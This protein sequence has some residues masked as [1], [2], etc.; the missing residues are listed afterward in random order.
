M[1]V[2]F[3][4]S[5]QIDEEFISSIK[6]ISTFV[7]TII[8]CGIGETK[9]K[10][11]Q[12]SSNKLKEEIKVLGSSLSSIKDEYVGRVLNDI[13]S[14]KKDQLKRNNKA[15]KEL[16][17]EL[18]P[19]KKQISEYIDY[20]NHVAHV[21]MSQYSDHTLKAIAD[22]NFSND[23]FYFIAFAL[24]ISSRKTRYNKGWDLYLEGNTRRYEILRE[25]NKGLD[26]F[27]KWVKEN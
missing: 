13:I 15:E 6:I 12:N 19:F 11:V 1:Q 21:F 26:S 9:L 27:I 4:S 20:I 7:S 24:F 17:K 16:L 22:D 8:E 5:K 2:N 25:A 23:E 14:E 3:R 18:A 10:Q